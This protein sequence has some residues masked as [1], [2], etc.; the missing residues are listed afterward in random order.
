MPISWRRTDWVA[1]LVLTIGVLLF[2]LPLWLVLA[3]STQS[4]ATIARGELSLIPDLSGLGIYADVLREGAQGATPV[5]RMLLVS[6]G[7]AMC[8]ALG[9]IAISVL[10]AYAIAFFRWPFRN[11]AFWIIFLTLM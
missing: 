10:S 1:H 5:W 9:K 8:I 6:F 11:L 2:A 3:G 4:A 7:M